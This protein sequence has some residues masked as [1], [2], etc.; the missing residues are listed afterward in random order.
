MG[1]PDPNGSEI[2]W[3]D[4]HREELRRIG[5][6][7]EVVLDLQRWRAG[8]AGFL[9]MKFVCESGAVEFIDE[10]PLQFVNSVELNAPPA[11]VFE[12]LRDSEAWLEWFP[13]MKSAVWDGEPGADADRRVQV[14]GIK[15]TE[16]F[17]IWQEPWQ[18]AFFV[19]ETSLPFA[20]RMVENY[21]VEETPTGSRFTYAVGMELRFPLS[22]L[23]FA[24]R[25]NF[26]KMFRNA[27]L[28]FQEY[29]N[30]QA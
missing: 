9:S 22:W 14:G 23:K 2:D 24:A 28:S 5:L 25:G 17:F 8:Q 19:S 3:L 26:E 12:A 29:V 18:M 1:S 11:V 15:L 21:T 13:D 6:P 30:Q 16:H 10:A 27:T 7:A 20:R 4:R